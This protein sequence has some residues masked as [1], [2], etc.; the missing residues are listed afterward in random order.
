MDDLFDHVNNL[1]ALAMDDPEQAKLALMRT[2]T[3]I[4]DRFFGLMK[5][6]TVFKKNTIAYGRKAVKGEEVRTV[7]KGKVETIN[8]VKDD[9]SWV[10]CEYMNG[11]RYI[12]SD[13]DF[14]KAYNPH[15]K[16]LDSNTIN[17]FFYH[18]LK[19]EGFK[20]YRSINKITVRRI[21]DDDMDWFR[22]LSNENEVHFMAPWG[23][24]MLIEEG[25]VIAMPVNEPG[26]YYRIDYNTFKETYVLDNLTST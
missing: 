17:I 6:G 24:P 20:E 22:D 13:A 1:I 5:K 11:E 3:E 25:D 15:G 19:N 21:F 12:L 10:M 16:E 26:K 4:N 18:S 2:Q 9:T 23:E 14:K 7:V 8:T